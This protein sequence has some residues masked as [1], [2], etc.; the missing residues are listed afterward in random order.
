MSFFC[1]ECST[2]SPLRTKSKVLAGFLKTETI[3]CPRPI[4]V[5]LPPTILPLQPQQPS[6]SSWEDSG[7][8]PVHLLFFRSSWK[9]LVPD[10]W[11]ACLLPSFRALLKHHLLREVCP[12]RFIYS[13]N[14][15]PA[16]TTSLLSPAWPSPFSV[17]FSRSV[18]SDS[19]QPHGLQQTRLP[20]PSSTP[21]ACLNSCPLSW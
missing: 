7:T 17:Q 11:T 18:V 1:P 20:C 5:T 2:L 15:S 8:G 4:S 12:G 19:L 9:V 21:G 13:H 3:S 6:R 16:S 14:P 10:N